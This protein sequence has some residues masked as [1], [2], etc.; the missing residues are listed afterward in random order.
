MDADAVRGDEV[1]VVLLGPDRADLLER[2]ALGVFDNE[3]NPDWSKEFLRDP[4][5]H[6]AVA[7]VGETVVGMASAVHYVHPDKPPELW[8]NEVGVAEPFQGQ[9]LGRKLIETLL[10]RG[11]ALGCRS[12][13]V[14]TEAD[15]AQAI[16]LYERVGGER[17]SVPIMFEFRLES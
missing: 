3:V 1:K 14:L 5:H 7:I 15:N 12:A 10:S 4:R 9:G 2:A 8:I 17:S 16:R 6:L 13:W 11:K